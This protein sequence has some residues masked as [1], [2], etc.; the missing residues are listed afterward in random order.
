V[1]WGDGRSQ[2][3]GAVTGTTPVLHVYDES[4]TYT[5]TG[6][7]TDIVGNSVTVSTNTF[8]QPAA[9]LTVFLSA[10]P[11]F[12]TT[13]TTESFT[14]TVIGLG[15]AVV[16]NYLWDFGDGRSASTSGNQIT[17][18]YAHPSGP[19]TVRVTVTTSTGATATGTTVINP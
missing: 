9:P 2:D 6:T 5:V 11:T 18:T 19:Y 16:V 14:A 12:G 3:L 10:T 8:V 1:S 17:Q 7:L 4:N 15:N 13:T